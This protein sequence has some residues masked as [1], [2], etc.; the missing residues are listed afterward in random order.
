VEIK[1]V[2]DEELMR[3]AETEGPTSA[4]A[5]ILDR[6]RM[7]R[8]KDHQVFAWQAGD[9]YFVGPV[10]DARTECLI[11]KFLDEDEQEE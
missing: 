7:K 9:Y 10:P 1:Q 4:A 6:L 11:M 5:A 2:S 3:L 8:A